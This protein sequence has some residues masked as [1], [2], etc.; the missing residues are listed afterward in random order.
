MIVCMCH[1]VSERDLRELFAAGASLP[2]V[3]RATGAGS[4]CGA[5][6]PAVAELGS[7]AGEGDCSSRAP[8]P[9]CPHRSAGS[10]RG[11]PSARAA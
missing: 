8:C 6:R 7:P 10:P 5:C 1:A 3:A 4:S 9:G 2:D 11:E